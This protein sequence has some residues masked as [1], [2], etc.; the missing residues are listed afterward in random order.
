LSSHGSQHKESLVN[1]KDF[2]DKAA[3]HYENLK[4]IKSN[5]DAPP[6]EFVDF[7]AKEDETI[8]KLSNHIENEKNIVDNSI[9]E[10]LTTF[11]QLCF[12]LKE[13]VFRKL[14]D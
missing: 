11:S 7:L 9:T 10:L 14:D 4:R 1:I 13:D 8:A 3:K 5:E 2:I 6:Q 12:K